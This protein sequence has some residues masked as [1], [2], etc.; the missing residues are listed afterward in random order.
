MNNIIYMPSAVKGLK[1]VFAVKQ[2]HIGSLWG[3]GDSQDFELCVS[4]EQVLW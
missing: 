3:L 1:K 2:Y 4:S